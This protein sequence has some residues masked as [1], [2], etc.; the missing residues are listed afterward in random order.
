[1]TNKDEEVGEDAIS[2]TTSTAG[3][4]KETISKGSASI[5]EL[6]SFGFG[7]RQKI[8]FLFGM[9]SAFITGLAYPFMTIYFG[10]AF[11]ELSADATSEE[12]QENIRFM[13]FVFMIL[14]VVIFVFMTLH[15]TLLDTMATEMTLAFKVDW[16]DALLRQDM[17]YHDIKDVSKSA[18][19]ISTNASKYRK[20][21]GRKLGEGVQYSVT[22][23]G[24]FIVAF[25]MSWRASLI[26]LA[27]VPV[28][29]LSVLFV[30]KANQSQTSVSTKGYA[31]AG[32]IVYTTTSSMRTILSLNAVSIMVTKFK[33]GT[34]KAYRLASSRAL[35]VGLANGSTMA[36]F[37][38]SYMLL[39]LYG[40]YLLYTL[41]REDGCDPSGAIPTNQTCKQSGTD[42]LIALFGITFGGAVL[43]Q[44]TISLGS[45]T[46][47]R[48]AAYPAILA[49]KRKLGYEENPTE[50]KN[51]DKEV[52]DEKPL[53][54][55]EI[56]SSSDV[57]AK[58]SSIVGDIEFRDVHFSYP[59]RPE[60]SIFNGLSL[61]IKSGQTVAL[62]GPS[63]GGK[64]TVVSMI[65][66]F[67]DP[68]EG[69]VTLDN[70][71]LK[72]LNVEWL[73]DQIGLVS[74]E[75]VLFDISIKENIA[76]GAKNV[77]Q[78]QIEEAAKMANAHD[79]IASFPNGYDTQV[80]DKGAQLSGG[81]KQRIA[82]A[83]T[84]IKNPKILLLDEATSALD[85][86]SE[87]H[88]QTALDRLLEST[89]RTTIVIAH[90]LSTIRDA[91][92]IAV[93]AGGKIVETGN[94][95]ELM[96]N[97]LGHYRR[98]V[99]I[100][101]ESQKK[102]SNPMSRAGS[103]GALN[104]LSNLVDQSALLTF[105]DVRFAYP[106]RPQ[107]MIFNGLNLSV[108]QGETLALVGSSGGGKSTVIQLTERFYD[109]ISGTIEL[110]GKPLPNINVK[111]LRDQIGLVQQEPTLFAT[112]IAENIKYG[113]PSATQKDI[114]EAAKLAN[115]HEF[116]STFP[117]GYQTQVG[118]RGTQISGGQK[119]RIAIARAIIKKP[120]IL[121]L[122]EATSALDSESEKVVQEALD[123]LMTAKDLTVIVIA[124]RLSTIRNANRI[125]VIGDGRVREIGTH[126]EL[127]AKPNGKYR[128]LQDLQSVDAENRE[129]A[130]SKM[131]TTTN[132]EEKKTEVDEDEKKTDKERT[133]ANASRAK[134]LAKG[135]T[136]YLA[137]GVVGAMFT[138]II[139]PGWGVAFA[140]MI[141]LLYKPVFKCDDSDFFKEIIEEFYKPLLPSYGTDGFCDMYYNSAADEM[142][143][144]S[145]HIT[146]GWVALI[147]AS[148]FGYALLFYGFGKSAE[149]MNKRVRDASFVALIRQ[150][151]SYFD[152]R[153]VG[154]ITT[155]LQDDAA[156]MHSFSGEPIR[157]LVM[158]VCSVLVGLIISFYYMWPFAL[159]CLAA[160]PAMGFGAA[161]E[162]KMYLGEDES[163]D[164]DAD[165][166]S[167]GSIV[168]ESLLNMRTVASL[169]IEQTRSDEYDEALNHSNKNYMKESMLNGMAIA[170]GQF[171]Q[172]WTFALMFFWGGWL[173]ARYPDDYSF[174]SY[175]ISMFALMFSLSGS[176]AAAQGL[177]DKDKAATAAE[178]I[179]ALIDRSSSI[180]PLSEEGKILN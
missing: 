158:N 122:D 104:L 91:D 40:A 159:L 114:E 97:S 14:G 128:R 153:S 105:K 62:V 3:E 21:L 178:R 81:Q 10:Q 48:V 139:F 41:V 110:N 94:H 82:I 11:E 174:R 172:M 133:K 70:M 37:M 9:T 113:L 20:G 144:L 129:K 16:F 26:V 52:S 150:E 148:M 61:K 7:L 143:D 28:M 89:N 29:S 127:M 103:G 106:S 98:L 163:G 168:I 145:I 63:G 166:K 170:F 118:E 31:D 87:F 55:Y 17:A 1:M 116:I 99:Q 161:M 151:I 53:P 78:G 51:K 119:Q 72:D 86:E 179:F 141:E 157:V 6:F 88:V 109:P 134:E 121:L 23:I 42:I 101:H 95:D 24:G 27:S 73:R 8:L 117:D 136:L 132:E 115:A 84:L 90:R 43:P 92:M 69:Q 59:A 74:Q 25:I 32:K 18:T 149:K 120:K 169:G 15:A 125:A 54:K 85:S 175:L 156:M 44:I 47:A 138:G 165:A 107:N 135:D 147:S 22:C 173:L 177:T 164:A 171:C 100:Q 19:I 33:E 30:T 56:D 45:F 176:A 154:S 76:Y 64:S 111:S 66:R 162:M 5:S 131:S 137:I 4:E 126:D 50:V 60:Q 152:V 180:D 130:K 46:A 77:T 140:Y 67:Y 36:S 75:P 83:R 35:I 142:R 57:G 108:H 13:C 167:S 96:K 2:T 146:Y 68:I 102:E 58:P 38:F 39:T 65:E 80:G 71:S 34:E 112:T 160:L 49:I 12:F 79:F 123:N 124:H 155:H 93:V